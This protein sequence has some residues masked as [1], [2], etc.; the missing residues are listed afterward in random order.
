MKQLTPLLML[1]MALSTPLLAQDSN[2]PDS[3]REAIMR[4]QASSQ[5]EQTARMRLDMYYGDFLS[6]LSGGDQRKSQV[7]AAFIEVLRESAELS[8]Q[9]SSGQNASGNLAEVNSYAYLRA[10]VAP[11]LTA[12]ELTELDA[13]QGG[14]SD[15]QLKQAYAQELSQVAPNLPAATG[16]LVLTTLVRH[17]REANPGREQIAQMSVNELVDLEAKSIMAAREE[18]QSQLSSEHLQQV[19]EFLY[20]VQGNLYRNRVMLEEDR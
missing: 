18:L 17:M 16:E 3:L 6:A 9:F 19:N 12:S 10:N 2:I 4:S 8:A 13:L 15:E 7:E 20:Q 1:T 11:L 5:V 14:P